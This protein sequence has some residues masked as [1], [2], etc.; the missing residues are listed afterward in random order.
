MV[1]PAIGP[2]APSCAEDVAFID[3]GEEDVAE[4]DGPDPIVDLVE[5]DN[6]LLER[7]RDEEQALFESDGPRVRHPL[8]N[9]MA[10][11]LDRRHVPRVGT[12]RRLV[13]RG[14]RPAPEKLVRTLVVVEDAEPVEGPLLCGQV[15]VGGRAVAALRVRCIR[16]WAPF[17]WGLAGRIR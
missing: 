11:V 9:V 14:G 17:C 1:S 10:R 13:Q 7:V 15:P 12:T 8:G 6:L 16:S 3:A 4:V 2:A 5:A